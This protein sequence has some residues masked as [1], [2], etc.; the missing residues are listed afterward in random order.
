MRIQYIHVC[1]V[2]PFLIILRYG[3]YEE[4]IRRGIRIVKDRNLNT[5]ATPYVDDRRN[6]WNSLFLGM[7]L[8]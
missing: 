7:G 3:I 8:Q 2:L 1:F 5:L 6:G 4:T